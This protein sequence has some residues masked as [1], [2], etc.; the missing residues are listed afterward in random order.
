[1]ARKK[2]SAE[3]IIGY[4]REVRFCCF[5]KKIVIAE[6]TYYRWHKE[7]RLMGS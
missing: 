7:C 6:Q 4:L 1:M 3:Q 2:Y 5:A